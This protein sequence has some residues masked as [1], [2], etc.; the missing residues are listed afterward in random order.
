MTETNKSS[1]FNIETQAG[2]P[3]QAGNRKITPFAT[4]WRLSIPGIS[5][6]LVW[7]RPTSIL[8]E[9]PEGDEAVQ[10]IPDITRQV[11]WALL[12]ASLAMAIL[13]WLTNRKR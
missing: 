10:A 2:S 13:V 7:N 6:G 5:G 3:I 8:I 11:L 12:G 1:W 9:S 4:S